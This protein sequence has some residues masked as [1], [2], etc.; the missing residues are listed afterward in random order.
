M[1]PR[2]GYLFYVMI[3][4]IALGFIL[5]FAVP[6]KA[7]VQR[8]K[9]VACDTEEQVTNWL[10]LWKGGTAPEEALSEVNT[11]AG[12][13]IA[14]APVDVMI[15]DMEVVK[16]LDFDESAVI[17]KMTVIGGNSPMGFFPIEPAVQYGAAPAKG[18]TASKT[19]I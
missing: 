12:N 16:E 1:E 11:A 13:E 4:L 17:L 2:N 14:C 5:S 7:D 9:G 19:N 15:S 8:Y 3:A 18:L 6:A 10:T